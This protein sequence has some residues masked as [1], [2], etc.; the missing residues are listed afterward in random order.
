MSRVLIALIHFYQRRISPLFGARCRYYPTCSHYAVDAIRAHGSVRGGLLAGWRLLRCNPFSKG[1]LD[2]VPA[3]R[4]PD[5]HETS[6][7]STL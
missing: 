5:A 3:R 7:R 4:H 1:G 6:L 2:P